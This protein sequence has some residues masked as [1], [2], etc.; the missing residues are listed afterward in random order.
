MSAVTLTLPENG[1]KPIIDG[2]IVS[3]L[4]SVRMCKTA[5]CTIYMYAALICNST[6]TNH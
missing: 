3:L 6:N 5:E 1:S 4:S 2:V